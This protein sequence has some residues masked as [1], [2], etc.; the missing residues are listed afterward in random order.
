M[1]HVIDNVTPDFVAPKSGAHHMCAKINFHTYDLTSSM[2]IKNSVQKK[3]YIINIT[4][5][6]EFDYRRSVLL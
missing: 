2:T 1:E 5:S 6:S 4:W 3:E